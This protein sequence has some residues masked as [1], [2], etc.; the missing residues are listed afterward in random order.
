MTRPASSAI[1]DDPTQTLRADGVWLGE[2]Q[3]RRLRW[4]SRTF[5][6]P[7]R[8]DRLSEACGGRTILVLDPPT[9]AGAELLVSSLT[10]HDAVV[11]P[12]GE[13]PAF[14]FLKSKLTEFGTVGASAD[15]PHELWWGGLGWP[16]P[17]GAQTSTP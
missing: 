3:A 6:P 15:G 7:V 14:D 4:V 13:N 1:H 12:L 16:A 9:G 17:V 11:I 2:H 5:G 10:S 8:W